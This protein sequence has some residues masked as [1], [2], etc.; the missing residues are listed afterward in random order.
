M[1]ISKNTELVREILKNNSQVENILNE[2]DK[3]ET[4]R[5]RDMVYNYIKK[6]NTYLSFR[7]NLLI[8]QVGIPIIG[9]IIT[10]FSASM[11]LWVKILILV[12]FLLVSLLVFWI[13]RV[14]PDDFDKFNQEVTRLKLVNLSERLAA[15]IALFDKIFEE[16]ITEDKE[17]IKRI[18]SF[19]ELESSIV[20]EDDKK[21]IRRCMD[22]ES[23]FETSRETNITI[24][25]EHIKLTPA[26]KEKL[27]QITYEISALAEYM[28]GGKG[29]SAKLYLR[30]LKPFEDETLEVLTSFSRFPLKESK[31]YG[32]SWVK[33]R[34]NPSIVWE[35]L[36][37]GSYK[38]AHTDTRS[39]LYYNSVLAICLP[40]RIGVLAI[41]GNQKDCFDD[42]MDKTTYNLLTFST[43]QL[44]LETLREEN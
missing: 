12:I 24:P 41:H 31:S 7:N 36:E 11:D 8:I 35:C 39:E 27:Q 42:K 9:S 28:F 40:G 29:Y 25:V 30:V 43:K 22:P 37:R 34:G 18:S 32:T 17:L 15:K 6:N 38:V 3:P 1:G 4:Q 13:A 10:A 44:L 20:S 33:S 21:I 19:V 16:D 23:R 26:G 14:L 5:F 2:F